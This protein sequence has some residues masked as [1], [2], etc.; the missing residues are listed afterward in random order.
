VRE[1][2][3][4]RYLVEVLDSLD[5]NISRAAVVL[6]MERTNVHKRIRQYGIKKGEKPV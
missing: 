1:R 5:G 4:R 6:G 3:E 2:A